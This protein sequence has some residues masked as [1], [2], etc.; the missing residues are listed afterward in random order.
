[1]SKIISIVSIVTLLGCSTAFKAK[2]E[3]IDSTSHRDNPPEWTQSQKLSW[4]KGSDVYL[5][6][7]YTVNGSERVNACMDLAKLDVKEKLLTEISS[8]V[9]GRMDNAQTSISDQAEIILG[10]VRSEEFKGRIIGLKTDESWFER[11][12]IEDVERIDCHV[13]TR[14]S[15]T[16]YNRIKREVIDKIVEVDP[17]LKEAIT[18]KQIEFFGDNR[19]PSSNQ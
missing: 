4:E 17:R 13:L 18:K 9:R 6:T 3:F 11:Y 2:R 1:M 19:N 14:L 5:R 8:D 16:D 7:S 12:K 10:K 15:K